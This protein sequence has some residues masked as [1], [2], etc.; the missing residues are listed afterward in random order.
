MHRFEIYWQFVL[1]PSV[2]EKWSQLEVERKEV[3]VF[4]LL[5]NV[6]STKRA[7]RMKAARA[8]LYLAQGEFRRMHSWC[9]NRKVVDLQNGGFYLFLEKNYRSRR[10]PDLWHLFKLIQCHCSS[11]CQRYL[12]ICRMVLVWGI[13][14]LPVWSQ[15]W[16]CNLSFPFTLFPC[17]TFSIGVGLHY[18]SLCND[19]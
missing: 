10:H 5:N 6:E 8:I 14:A 18:R 13:L 9:Y 12:S 7:T 19:L 17:V 3:H 15:E 16:S 11:A 2:S 4:K 1:F